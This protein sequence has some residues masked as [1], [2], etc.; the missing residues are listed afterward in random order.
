MQRFFWHCYT[1]KHYCILL[2]NY[3]LT[4]EN[5]FNLYFQVESENKYER[6]G[7]TS[8][9]GGTFWGLGSLLTSAKVHLTTA[10]H[11]TESGAELN[12]IRF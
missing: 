12:S 1:I 11:K 7:G 8:M 10:K 5:V 4:S 2:H 9:G 6:V 3:L